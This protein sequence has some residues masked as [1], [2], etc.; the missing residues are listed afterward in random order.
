MVKKFRYI[1]GPVLA[2]DNARHSGEPGRGLIPV[3]IP[4]CP[5]TRYGRNHSSRGDH[6]DTVIL[7][8]GDEQV[9]AGVRRHGK[10][11][12]ELGSRSA[13]VRKPR[14]GACP[15]GSISGRGN[16]TNKAIRL[17]THKQIAAVIKEHSPRNGELRTG[18]RAVEI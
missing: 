1:N 2:Y 3:G 18:Q 13:A 6:A 7:P 14:S 10:R 8:V 16:F 9:A 11:I 12:V 5:I 17:V 15:G 4:G